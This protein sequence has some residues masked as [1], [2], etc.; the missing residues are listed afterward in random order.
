MVT[1][2][3]NNARLALIQPRMMAN[4]NKIKALKADPNANQM[5]VQR[6]QLDTRQL[7]IDNNCNPLRGLIL[8]LVQMPLFITFFFAL[9]GMATSGLPDF[10]TGG[11]AWFTDLSM[12]DPYYVL[13]VLS[14]AA[15]LAVL[16]VGEFGMPE[17]QGVA[18]GI[19]SAIKLATPLIIWFTSSF[20]AVS[21]TTAPYRR[22]LTDRT[23][24]L[25]LF[26]GSRITASPFCRHS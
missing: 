9:R 1:G 8:P 4:I 16:Q 20:P 25:F 23:A 7:L 6:I 11:A 3:A 12:P 5:E 21:R 10:A 26:T 19:R 22:R 13:P 2:I 14:S 18:K 17:P 24:R 15:T